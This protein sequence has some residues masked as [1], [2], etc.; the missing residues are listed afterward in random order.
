MKNCVVLLLFYLQ[1]V[2]TDL[3]YDS[4][5]YWTYSKGFGLP[6][7]TE[8]R[9]VNDVTV[10]YY[11]SSLRSKMPCPD[12]INTTA[13]REEWSSI[14]HWTDHNTYVSALGFQSATQQFNL[15]GLLSDQN[16]Y[17]AFGCCSL[18]SN[19]TYR[20][21]VTHSFNGKD[22]LS[23]DINSK[24]FVAAVPQAVLYRNLRKKDSVTIE[25]LTVYYKKTCLERL[26][27]FKQ[28]PGLLISKV[29]EVRIIEQ[30]K[31]GSITV[32][33]HVTGFYPR[34]VQVV[35]LGPDLQPVDE[36][37]TDVLPNEDGTYQTRKS[38]IVPEEDVGE[39]TY[40]CVVLHSSVPDNI[41]RVWG[42]EKAGGMAVWISLVCICLLA[43][44]IGLVVWWCC[45][46]RAF[47]FTL[48]SSVHIK[49]SSSAMKNACVL[50]LVLLL[51]QVRTDLQYESCVYWTSSK[52][53]GLPEYTERIVVNDVTVY[54]HDS[55]TK[56]KMP[57]PDWI[58]TTAGREQWSI[59]HD[60]SDHNRFVSTLGLQSASKQ[61]NLTG[62]LSG[63]NI[64]Q[65]S[66]C[67]SLYPDG[68]Y[69]AFVT[70]AFNGKD[71]TSF[72]TNTKTFVAAVPQAVL[73]KTL[74]ERDSASI[75]MAVA[76]GKKICRERLNIL[77][78]APEVHIRKVPEVRIVEQQKAGSVTV[79]CHVT[80]FY[81]RVVQVVWL[82]PDL[83]SVDEGVTDVLPNE[84]GTYQTRKSVIVP[85][86]DVGEHTYSCVV[87][88]SS[89]PDNITRV[90]VVEK[91]S[92]IAVW[93]S[94]VCVCLLVICFGVWNRCRYNDAVS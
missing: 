77:K 61:F 43:A 52:G 86:E 65:G 29:P 51:Q 26:N 82:G 5:G 49:A 46:T 23:F 28:A 69:R 56:S 89:V 35:W 3:Q 19:G 47:T 64:Y 31:A 42:G 60:F 27:I 63:Q 44:G 85:E 37:V 32:T 80:G 10:Y 16:I 11:D 91:R 83:Q 75:G 36:G 68:T 58:N 48:L 90:W 81:P 20:A 30:Q 72:D 93:T 24:T 40:S 21:F 92:R 41:T 13:G 62:S 74:R 14:H 87:L 12:W 9:V 59:I 57:C 6:E 34:V 53:Y 2:R 45:R 70:H 88:H 71:F 54:Y 79:T 50:I 4:C 18:D 78:Q 66:G 94:L 73:Y 7:F 15:T 84:D 39:H 38:V 25:E 8:R 22:F 17:Q 33:C 55:R 76:Y 67:C 1:Q